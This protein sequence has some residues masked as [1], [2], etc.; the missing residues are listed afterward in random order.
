MSKR[1]NKKAELLYDYIGELI[2]IECSFCRNKET[3]AFID[4]YDYFYKKGWRIINDN[5]LCPSC[6]RK[7]KRK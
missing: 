1:V 3:I 6:V 4:D 5:C 7:S 2:E